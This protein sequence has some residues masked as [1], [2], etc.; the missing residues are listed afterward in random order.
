M[1]GSSSTTAGGGIGCGAGVLLGLIF[2]GAAIALFIMGVNRGGSAAFLGG[3]AACVILAI[4]IPVT[5]AVRQGKADEDAIA[6][7]AAS[8]ARVEA[9]IVDVRNSTSNRSALYRIIAQGKNP[10]TGELHYF[11][12][13]SIR[14]DPSWHLRERKTVFVAVDRSD[15]SRG[16]MDFS[17][18]PGEKPAGWTSCT[19]TLPTFH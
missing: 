1:D 7:V 17:F 12:G 10:V 4:A 6:A 2:L 19:Q 13:P 18:M 14:R 9:Q 5:V 8:G 3:A 11:V 15:P 16:V